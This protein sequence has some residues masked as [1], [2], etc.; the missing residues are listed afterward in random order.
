MTPDYAP[1]FP[2]EI[3]PLPPD[4]L[5][6]PK[7]PIG[8]VLTQGMPKKTRKERAAIKARRKQGAKARKR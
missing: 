7:E 6:V 8:R 2:F 1:E 3:R 5:Q 4:A